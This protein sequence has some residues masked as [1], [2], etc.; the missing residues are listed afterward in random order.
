[1]NSVADTAAALRAHYRAARRALSQQQQH[2]AAL[3]FAQQLSASAAFHH[4]ESIAFYVAADGEVDLQPLIANA[5]DAGKRCFL[6]VANP[7]DFS[8]RFL[9]YH[10]EKSELIQNRWGLF[11]PDSSLLAAVEIAPQEL[12]LVF[13]PLVACD[14]LGTRLGMGKGFYD[15]AFAFTTQGQ[16]DSHP[17]LVGAAH[18]C[19]ISER[20]LARQDW[21]V[22]LQ[23]IATPSQLLGFT[24]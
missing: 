6:P 24:V 10:G 21:D 23:A 17:L 18:D 1:M 15:R 9:A 22:P 7:E 13:L 11:E 20:P 2:A 4:A 14:A 5:L 3:S 8:L 12:D 16:S 19:Q